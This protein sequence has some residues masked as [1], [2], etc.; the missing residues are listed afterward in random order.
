MPNRLPLAAA[1]LLTLQFAIACSDGTVGPD[2]G[3]DTLGFANSSGAEVDVALTLPNGQTRS[4]ALSASRLGE[5]TAV[6][7]SFVEGQVYRFVLSNPSPSIRPSLE[8]SCT[9]SSAAV[10]DGVAG[11]LVLLDPARGGLMGQCLTNWVES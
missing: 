3:D 7:V 9:V 10:R 1:L 5:E 4:V 6:D 8:T 2:G 11:V